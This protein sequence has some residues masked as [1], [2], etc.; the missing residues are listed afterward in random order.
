MER[1]WKEEG[2]MKEGRRKE[3]R[4]RKRKERKWLGSQRVTTDPK[5]ERAK[6]EQKKKRKKKKKKTTEREKDRRIQN[7]QTHLTDR[8]RDIIL[9]FSYIYLLLYCSIHI[10]IF[11][12]LV[13]NCRELWM[14]IAPDRW[15]QQRR[16]IG[17]GS[18]P[19][20][21]GDKRE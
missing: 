13:E 8:A 14:R 2:E 20:D 18:V 15:A 4:R 10:A 1:R 12:S 17:H 19:P 16:W 5:E 9:L 7:A 3:E 21:S 11:H 6:G